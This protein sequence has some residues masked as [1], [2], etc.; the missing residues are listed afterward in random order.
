MLTPEQNTFFTEFYRQHFSSMV[1]YAYRFIGNWHE[2]QSLVQSSF[3]IALLRI[4]RFCSSENPI[5][6][7]KKVIRYTAA[8]ARRA[9]QRRPPSVP[10]DDLQIPV[11][12]PHEV[13]DTLL[14]RCREILTPKEYAL[15]E[16][17]VL[18]GEPATKVHK[19]FGLSYEACKKRVTRILAKLRKNLREEK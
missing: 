13:D 16:A 15:F 7:L 19:S 6:W 9:Q 10:L 5:G 3:E 17:T 18:A 4:N 2:A 1:A 14:N 12:D 8:N 11:Y